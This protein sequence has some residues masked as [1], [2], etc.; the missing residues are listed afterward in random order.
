[1]GV[2]RGMNNKTSSKRVFALGCF[3]AGVYCGCVNKDSLNCG[4]FI[5]A[6]LSILG[7]GA[8]TKT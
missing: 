1:M 2:F 8:I 6:A 7:I 3:I 4:I 5:G